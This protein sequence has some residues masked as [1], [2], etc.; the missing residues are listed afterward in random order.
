MLDCEIISYIETCES[1][2][3]CEPWRRVYHAAGGTSALPRGEK[4][5]F[6]SLPLLF[7]R[8]IFFHPLSQYIV[9]LHVISLITDMHTQVFSL[10]WVVHLIHDWSMM[11]RIRSKWQHPILVISLKP[12]PEVMLESTRNLW[13]EKKERELAH[14]HRWIK[15]LLHYTCEMVGDCWISCGK[16]HWQIRGFRE[17]SERFPRGFRDSE[18][19][20]RGIQEVSERFNV[21]KRSPRGSE[22]VSK[23]SPRGFWEVSERFL[24]GL[25][26]VPRGFQEVSERFRRGIQEVS[27]RF[28][29]SKWSPTGSEEVSKRSPRGFWGVSERFFFWE[30][31]ERFREVS[32]RFPRGLRE[33][34]KRYPRGLRELVLSISSVKPHMASYHLNLVW[35]FVPA[36]VHRFWWFCR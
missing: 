36:I 3:T 11:N 27:E 22:E 28:N 8:I 6:P 20:R 19:F 30:V 35:W 29:V 14:L 9:T 16:N 2:D 24:R 31:S 10:G 1:L 23:R 26:E 4:N 25:R 21:S 15:C 5:F 17:V 13:L 18:R 32:K 12:S 33:V 34:P 7:T